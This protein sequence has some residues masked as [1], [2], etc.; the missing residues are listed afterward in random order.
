MVLNIYLVSKG[1]GSPKS[2]KQHVTGRISEDLNSGNE[3][4]LSFKE[5]K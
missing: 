1:H 3:E 4:I 5:R 2:K